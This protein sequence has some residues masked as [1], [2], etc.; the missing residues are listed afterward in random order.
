MKKKMI[1][2]VSVCVAVLIGFCSILLLSLKDST[3]EYKN[4]TISLHPDG[5]DYEDFGFERKYRLVYYDIS[6]YFVDLVSRD[7]FNDWMMPFDKEH[8]GKEL[9]EMYLVSF[10]KHFNIPK[11]KFVEA[12]EEMKNDRLADGLDVYSEE[13][14][15]P[16]ADIIYTFD[17]EIINNYYRRA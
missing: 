1:L 3:S 12:C 14:E 15:I 6:G 16:N 10:I 9:S 13:Y 8:S 7:E 5:Y 11:D 4:G 17:N 2:I